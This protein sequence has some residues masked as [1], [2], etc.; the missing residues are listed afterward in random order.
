VDAR[1]EL[2]QRFYVRRRGKAKDES[3]AQ[4]AGQVIVGTISFGLSLSS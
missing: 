3:I 1:V 2:R 4:V